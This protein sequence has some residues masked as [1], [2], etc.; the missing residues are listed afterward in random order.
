MCR[1]LLLVFLRDLLLQNWPLAGKCDVFIEP[2]LDEFDMF[3]VKQADKIF[4]IGYQSALLQKE[5]LSLL[6]KES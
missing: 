4:N 6:A 5:K 3:N 1:E 2:A